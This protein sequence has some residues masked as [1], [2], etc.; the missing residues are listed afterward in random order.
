MLCCEKIYGGLCLLYVIYF[1]QKL[2]KKASFHDIK[3][4]ILTK[5]LVKCFCKKKTKNFAT[6]K[7]C[8]LHTE[9]GSSKRVLVD[10]K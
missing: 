10:L 3:Y 1:L 5:K 7:A 4:T 9:N 8:F 6:N 2:N